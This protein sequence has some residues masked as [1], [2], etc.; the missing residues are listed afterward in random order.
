MLYF[1]DKNTVLKL[2]E[3]EAVIKK[4]E[5]QIPFSKNGKINTQKVSCTAPN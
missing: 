1:V 3:S 5:L 2:S 4:D